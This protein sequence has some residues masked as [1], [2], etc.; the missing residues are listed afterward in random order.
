MEFPITITYNQTLRL[1]KTEVNKKFPPTS[2]TTT[3][4]RRHIQQV[5]CITPSGQ[6]RGCRFGNI[7]FGRVFGGIS[8]IYHKHH[9][10]TGCSGATHGRPYKNRPDNKTTTINTGQQVK[11]YPLFRFM[12]WIFQQTNQEDPDMLKIHR[13]V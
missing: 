6:G 13:Q 1:F 2:T 4:I 9:G 12:G 5:V 11:Y 8:R 10:G 7:N 3:H